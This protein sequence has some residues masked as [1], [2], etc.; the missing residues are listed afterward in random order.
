M[1]PLVNALI[2]ALLIATAALAGS[3]PVWALDIDVDVS[4]G[5]V[6]DFVN[7]VQNAKSKQPAGPAA[8]TSAKAKST[9]SKALLPPRGETRLID[10]EVLVETAEGAPVDALHKLASRT[11]LSLIETATIA[12]LNADVHRFR[13]I[14]GRSV[15]AVLASLANEKLVL[16]AQPNYGYVVTGDGTIASAST[17]AAEPAPQKAPQYVVGLLHLEDAH[18]IANGKSVVIGLL[19]T[20][21]ADGSPEL[22]GSIRAS[23]DPVGGDISADDRSHGTSL[24]GVIV[25]HSQLTG[26]S[27]AASILCARAFVAVDGKPPTSNTFVL[28]KGLDWLVANGA[29]LINMSF[30]GPSDPLFLK[31]VDAARGK[32]VLSI[33]AVGNDG[34]QSKPDYPAADPTV[35]GV[36]AID[37]ND[38]VLGAANQGGAG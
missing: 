23:Y 10:D 11:H 22:A 1:R 14:D 27:P 3:V 20:A 34:P 6:F 19:D 7:A 38:A 24:A 25:A 5:D 9:P 21:V 13:I 28:L 37:A 2:A 33:A 16:L 36:T 26:V 12:L 35:F 8:K 18:A 30:A 32:G 17:P 29:R 31:T 4:P 15:R